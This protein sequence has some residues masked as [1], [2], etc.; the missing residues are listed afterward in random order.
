MR[1]WIA[2]AVGLLVTTACTERQPR[3]PGRI[4]AIETEVVGLSGLT[5]DEHGAFWAPGEDAGA[6]LRVDAETGA[7]TSY[8]VVGAPPGVELEALAW[9]EGTRFVVGTETQRAGRASDVVFDGRIQD[10][11]FEIA[12]IGQLDYARW[13]LAAPKNHGIEGMCHVAGL[14]VA[15]TELVEEH[16]GRRWAPLAVFDQKIQAWAAHRVA[17]T[18]QTGKLA[19]LDCRVVDGVIEALAVERH[20]GVSRLL[21]F[22]VPRG[23]EPQWIETTVA[24]DLEQLVSPLPNFEGLSWTQGGSVVLLTDNQY[25]GPVKEP[26]RMYWVPATEVR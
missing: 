14:L 20:F 6:V 17:L 22:R 10:N 16:R 15:A 21:R 24:A 9:V 5:R 11:R 18:S 19:A 3:G 23:A 8:V 7:V 12:P 26:T 25:R 2:A 1:V 13:G 4:D